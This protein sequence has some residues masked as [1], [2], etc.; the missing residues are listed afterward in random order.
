MHICVLLTMHIDQQNHISQT[1]IPLV[2]N[3]KPL[4]KAIILPEEAC[5][6][7]STFLHVLIQTYHPQ[8]FKL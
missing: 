7:A 2:H 3:H 1:V 4:N 6:T 5:L 8:I